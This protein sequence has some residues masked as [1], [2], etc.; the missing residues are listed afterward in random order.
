ML[1]RGLN[2]LRIC[3]SIIPRKKK[4]RCQSNSLKSKLYILQRNKNNLSLRSLPISKLSYA[5]GMKNSDN[6]REKIA[7]SLMVKM[8]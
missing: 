2:I 6:A 7:L 8:K 1:M 5:S 3:G 4:R